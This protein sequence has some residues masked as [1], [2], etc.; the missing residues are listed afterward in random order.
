MDKITIYLQN[1]HQIYPGLVINSANLLGHGQFNDILQINDDLIF[2]FPRFIQA[3]KIMAYEVDA[4]RALHKVLT[5][6]PI[7]DPIYI[8]HNASLV[9]KNFMGYRMLAGKPVSQEGIKSIDDENILDRIASQIGQFLRELHTIPTDMLPIA[10]HHADGRT[11]WQKTYQAFRAQLFPYIRLDAREEVTL[12]FETFLNEPRHFTYVPTLRHGDFGGSNIL[13][14]T[15]SQRISGIIDFSFIAIGDPAYD[16][17]SISTC[18]DAF[19]QRICTTYPEAQTMLARARF[20]R[21]TF[22]LSQALYGL[23]NGDHASFEDG[24]STYI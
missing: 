16:I 17:A 14:D 6:L 19:L 22:A 20:Y 5:T 23:R 11:E 15:A 1:I 24:I 2:R 21:S 13:Y 7:P 8:N 3:A 10:P 12:R 18:G 9:N 4:L